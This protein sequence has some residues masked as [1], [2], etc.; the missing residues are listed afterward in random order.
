MPKLLADRDTSATGTKADAFDS[1]ATADGV[2]STPTIL[3]GKT[4]A[5]PTVVALASATDAAAVTA[6]IRAALS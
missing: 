2:N 5:R 4:G 6:A 3:F 1:Q